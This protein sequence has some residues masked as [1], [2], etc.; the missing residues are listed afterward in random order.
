M[1]ETQGFPWPWL[2]QATEWQLIRF[3][4]ESDHNVYVK[5]QSLHILGGET[6]SLNL[7][8]KYPLKFPRYPSCIA[9]SSIWLHHPCLLRVPMVGRN[10][11]RK[12]R[13]WWK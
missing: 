1:S 4:S 8:G 5:F 6:T 12:E 9:G 11:P 7:G 3:E 10:Q 2:G 13:M